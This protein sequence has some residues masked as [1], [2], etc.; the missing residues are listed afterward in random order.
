MAATQQR[1]YGAGA[2][3]NY[4]LREGVKDGVPVTH[5][6]LQKLISIG[7][8][9]YYAAFEEPLFQE[10]IAAWPLGPVV[11]ELYHEFKRFGYNPITSLAKMF[12]HTDGKFYWPIVTDLRAR[13]VLAFVWRQYGTNTASELVKLTHATGTPW[14]KAWDQGRREIADN[15]VKEHYLELAQRLREEGRRHAAD[16]MDHRVA[17]SARV[18][19]SGSGA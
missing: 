14:R 6:K 3:A 15:D 19:G 8:G 17:G 16:G 9:F 4:F 18:V 10:R 1:E 7:Y 12:N 13:A 5:L 11:P 2:V